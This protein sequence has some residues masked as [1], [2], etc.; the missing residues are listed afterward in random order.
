MKDWPKYYKERLWLGDVD[1]GFVG[2][3]TLWTPIEVFS[4]LVDDRLKKK[5]SVI[6]QLH[7]K[8][9]VEFIF[10]NLWLNPKIR[11]L[12]LCG[13]DGCGAGSALVEFM[14]RGKISSLF[15][16]EISKRYLEMV[17]S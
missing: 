12:I 1:E 16:D 15:F 7:T 11:Y 3:V 8:R 6:G 9:G 5:V 13:E 2:I 4:S 17:L 14:R 10:R